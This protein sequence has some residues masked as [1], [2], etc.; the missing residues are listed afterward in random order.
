VVYTIRYDPGGMLPS[1][2]V[3]MLQNVGVE[4]VIDDLHRHALATLPGH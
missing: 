2:L 3:R 1:Y 4:R